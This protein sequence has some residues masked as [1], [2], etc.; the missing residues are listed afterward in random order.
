VKKDTIYA[1]VRCSD[2]RWLAVNR[3]YKPFGVGACQWSWF[4]YDYCDGIRLWL[5]NRDLEK[6]DGGAR[7][8]QRGDRMIW[9][10]HEITAPHLSARRLAAYQQRLS[11]LGLN[12]E[13]EAA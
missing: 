4:Y 5:R 10:Y 11:V 9:L 13:E 1:L 2:G 12:E 3:R 6:I 7:P 8:Y